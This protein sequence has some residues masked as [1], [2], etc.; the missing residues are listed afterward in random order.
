[1][2]SLFS[3][4]ILKKSWVQRVNHDE[5]QFSAYGI[6]QDFFFIEESEVA[7]VVLV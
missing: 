4:V 3:N 5:L 1:M 2:S 6:L 7:N